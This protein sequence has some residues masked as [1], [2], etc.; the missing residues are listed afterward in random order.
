MFHRCF[1]QELADKLVGLQIAVAGEDVE[2]MQRKMLVEA[3]VY[4]DGR[5]MT[6][7]KGATIVDDFIAILDEYLETKFGEH[8]R[9]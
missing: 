8:A 5:L 7:L 2:P 9:K 3:P 6:T 4:V 1:C